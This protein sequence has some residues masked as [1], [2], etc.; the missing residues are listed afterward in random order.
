MKKK[1]TILGSTGSIGVSALEVIRDFKDRFEVV[2]FTT[3]R[4]V[5]LLQ[6]QIEEFHP[7]VACVADTATADKAKLSGRFPKTRVLSGRQSLTDMLL[8]YEAD[9]LVVATVG[10]VGLFPTLTGIECGMRIGLANKEVLVIAGE[11]VTKRARKCQV[12]ILPIDSEHNA[13]FQCLGGNDASKIRRVILTASGGP[14]RDFTAEQMRKVTRAQALNHP[15]WKMGDK[16][17][18]DSATLMNKGFEV[19][20]ACHLFGVRPDQVEVVVHPQSAVHSMVEFVDGSIL[21]QLGQTSMYLP[22]LNVLSFPERVS[23]KYE[24]LDLT[25]LARL[26]FLKPDLERFPCLRYAYEACETGGTMP[27]A[28]NAAN[29]VAVAAF[30]EERIPFYG[31]PEIIRAVMDEHQTITHPDLETLRE[32]D[33]RAREMAEKHVGTYA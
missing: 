21:A 33:Q 32:T 8:S 1:V 26:D 7:Q 18:I 28:M 2:G 3:N 11:L 6:K 31:I 24:P 16:I 22:I 10:F 20:E 12:E 5:D 19:I 9:I 13:V 27:A 29:E 14:F 4:N 23:N 15:T 25:R 30:L 17:T